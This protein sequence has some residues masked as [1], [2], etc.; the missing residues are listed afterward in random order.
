[1][2]KCAYFN[3]LNNFNMTVV[4]IKRE[5]Y[6]T[7]KRTNVRVLWHKILTTKKW[8]I[9]MTATSKVKAILKENHMNIRYTKTALYAYPNLQAI[10]EQIDELVEKKALSSMCNYTPALE[11]CEKIVDFTYQKD[12][13]FALNIYVEEAL[14]DISQLEMDC[15]E[16]KYFKRKEKEYFVGFDAESRGYFR[17]QIRIIK[18][19]SEKLEK[20]GATDAWFEQNCLQM[21]FFKELLKR[22]IEHENSTKKEK[23]KN[24]KIKISDKSAK[25]SD[26]LTA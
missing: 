23:R 2:L 19:L 21:D 5:Y 3:C 4:V 13:L 10:A 1:M 12:V 26:R 25:E 14:K 8:D 9:I 6:K 11:Q 20:A 16:Y 15:L 7:K 22:V 24:P 18:K 17:R